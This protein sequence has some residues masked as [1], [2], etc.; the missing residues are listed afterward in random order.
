[1]AGKKWDVIVMLVPLNRFALG[2]GNFVAAG[3]AAGFVHAGGEGISC[4]MTTGDLASKAILS[5]A[6]TGG[7][8]H[9]MYRETVRDEAELCLDQFNPLKMIR[10]S[11]IPLDFKA[12]WRNYSL[13]ELII[14]W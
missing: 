7:H 12:V 11:P 10:K 3:D 5:A 9:D 2:R 14:L 13:K 1:M 6:T 4:A 8:A